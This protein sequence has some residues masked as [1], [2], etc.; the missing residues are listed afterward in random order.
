MAE[1]RRGRPFSFQL[2][3][4]LSASSSNLLW[5]KNGDAKIRIGADR[6]VN[7]FM[8][9]CLISHPC[10]RLW[11]TCVHKGMSYT[12]LESKNNRNY[13]WNFYM[14]RHFLPEAAWFTHPVFTLRAELLYHTSTMSSSPIADKWWQVILVS[15]LLCMGT[16]AIDEWIW[17]QGG[18]DLK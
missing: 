12:R 15:S 7:E 2:L 3:A 10:W 14:P 17:L 11:W 4:V 9:S 8:R 13:E 16:W 18:I 6:N 5:S 1:A